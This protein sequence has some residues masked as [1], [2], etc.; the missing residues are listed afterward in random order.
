VLAV[1]H[2]IF[3]LALG[4]ELDVVKPNVEVGGSQSCFVASDG[5]NNAQALLGKC[6]YEVIELLVFIF[7]NPESRIPSLEDLAAN[8]VCT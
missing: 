6:P 5:L 7:Y 2:L 1:G 3:E 8:K 4:Y